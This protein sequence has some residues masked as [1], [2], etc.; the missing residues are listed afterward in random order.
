MSGWAY[1]GAA[2]ITALAVAGVGMI[3]TR[4]SMAVADES[5]RLAEDER[6]FKAREATYALVMQWLLETHNQISPWQRALKDGRPPR[7]ATLPTALEPL[8]HATLARV[9]TVGSEAIIGSVQDTATKVNAA[10]S[11]LS[12]FE[13]IV[14]PD[15]HQS[16]LDRMQSAITAINACVKVIRADLG[17]SGAD[18]PRS[19]SGG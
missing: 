16:A 11:I 1:V 5:R 12:Q 13:W 6:L 9:F 8:P 18:A 17:S 7:G 15:K 14:P 3:T 19:P 10:I 2:L 4:T